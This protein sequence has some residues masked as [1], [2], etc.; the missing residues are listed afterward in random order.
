MDVEKTIE[1]LLEHQARFDARFDAQMDNLNAQMSGLTGKMADLTDKMDSMVDQQ[2]GMEERHDREIADIRSALRQA[3]R[4]SIEEQRRERVR[5]QALDTKVD[6]LAT[7]LQGLI[8]AMKKSLN[9][10]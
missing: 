6:S 4:L 2:I 5:R 10:H 9:G 7:S 8:D 1:F 3:V